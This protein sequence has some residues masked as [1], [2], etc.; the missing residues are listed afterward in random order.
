MDKL[1]FDFTSRYGEMFFRLE[2]SESSFLSTS[3]FCWNEDMFNDL[4][5]R[6]TFN[7]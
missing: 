6:M 2:F 4:Q 1:L 7:E 5:Q 3:C